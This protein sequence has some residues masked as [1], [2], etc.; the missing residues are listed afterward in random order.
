MSLTPQAIRSRL[1]TRAVGKRIQCVAS[2]DSTNDLAWAEA[3]KGAEHG[4]AIFAEEQRRGRGRMGRTWFAP[5]G[6][7]ILCSVVLRPELEVERVPLV[8]AIAALAA[9]D[10]VDSVAG[11]ESRIRFPNDV[12]VGEKKIAGVL[13]ESR[14]ISGRPD[15]FVIGVGINGNVGAEDF[16]KDLRSI[17]TSLELERGERVNLAHAA[18]ALLEALDRWVEELEGGLRRIQKAWR[19]RSAILHR[20]VRVLE[21]GRTYAGVVEDLDPIEGLEVRMASGSVR[22]FRGEHVER[23]EMA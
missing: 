13:V 2:A 17:A 11:T 15:L 10:A 9:S 23:L 16:P 6:S 1:T 22:H 7:S 21:G 8:T 5:K 19:E 3:V 4:F 20:P 12:F 14:F 18:R